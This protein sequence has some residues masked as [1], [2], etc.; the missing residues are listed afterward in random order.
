MRVSDWS[1]DVCSADLGVLADRTQVGD[2]LEVAG[3]E[4]GAAAGEVGPLRQRM[5][6][7]DALDAVVQD[8]AGRPVPGE[9]DVALVGQDRDPTATA[10]LGRRPEVVEAAGGVAGGVDPQADRKSTRLNSSH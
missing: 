4:A 10:P 1:S 7:Q 8:R 3:V 5:D 2:Q 6:G 9:G